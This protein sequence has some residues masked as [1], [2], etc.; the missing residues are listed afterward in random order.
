MRSKKLAFVVS[1]LL[2]G[3]ADSDAPPEDGE[4]TFVI[5]FSPELGGQPIACG[6]TFTGAGTRGSSFELRDF[7]MFVYD[8]Q[9]VR[10]GGERVPLRLVEDQHWQGRG[11]TLLDFEDGTGLCAGDGETND[12]VVGTAPDHDDYVGLSFAVGL[13]PELNHLDAVTASPPFNKPSTWW[14]WKDGYKFFQLTMATPAHEFFYVH[15][16]ATACDGTV[17]SGFTCNADH[18]LS[19]EVGG[20]VPGEDGV[21]LNVAALLSELDLEAPVDND[22]GDFVAGC[23]SFDPDPE[24]DPVFRKFGRHF[25]VDDP[26]P[27]QVVFEP[28]AGMAAAIADP[29]DIDDTPQPGHPDFP[30][31]PSLDVVRESRPDVAASH[32]VGDVYAIGSRTYARGPGAQCMFC[33]QP[34]G[35][36]F[37]LFDV[38]GTIWSSDGATPYAEATVKLL[39][40]DSG[41][42]LELDEREHCVDRPIGYYREEDVV[43]TLVTD[44]NGNLYSTELPT[45]AQPPLW[46]VVV[47]AEGSGLAPKFM[48]F[49][50]AAGSCNMCHA[51]LRIRLEAAP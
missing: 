35:P 42:C 37:G 8:V 14:G 7:V 34:K 29:G 4:R 31:D 15:L 39:P 43:A 32:P 12:R 45:E 27:Q 51:A 25:L 23:M 40:A 13:P 6:P 47:P 46:P 9:L 24:C 11:V 18:E 28:V 44:P 33:H 1:L 30:R 41:P 2:S 5:P 10:E 48:P 21:L 50:A 17:E 16:G 36:G 38:A 22:A 49:P 20:F 3:C 19:I 26:G